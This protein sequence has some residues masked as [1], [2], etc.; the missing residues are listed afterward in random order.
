MAD[1]P[2]E[3]R[4]LLSAVARIAGER[5]T[6]V[7]LV[8]GAVRD[9]LLGRRILDVD[10]AVEGDA[11]ALARAAADDVGARLRAHEA[12]GTAVVMLATGRRVDLAGTRSEVYPEVAALPRVRPASLADD[13][14]RRDFT[15]NSMAVP[16]DDPDGPPIDPSGGAGDLAARRLRVHHARSFL[17]DP[18]RIV[19]GVRFEARLGFRLG[20]ETERLARQACAA[21]AVERLSAERLR[22]E[23]ELLFEDEG[24]LEWT[25]RRLGELGVLAAA[26]LDGG[27]GAATRLG[28]VSRALDGWT[29]RHGAEYEVRR[30]RTLLAAALRTLPPGARDAAARRL[31]IAA[32]GAEG[33]E[34]LVRAVGRPSLRPRELADTLETLD[35][36]ELVLLEALGGSEIGERV[37]VHLAAQRRLELSIDGS[38][39]LAHGFAAGPHIGAA[40]RATRAARH[41]GLITAGEELAFALAA[42]RGENR[43]R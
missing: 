6:S 16:L 31:G 26:G 25:W 19:R 29:G 34:D 10:L 23:L 22:T 40:L 38:T 41:D 11:I 21:H 3:V 27:E 20:T 13:L 39:L 4:T 36:E 5:E 15:V 33:F 2:P 17:D 9:R 32:G 7:Y 30:S 8:G 43:E 42:L 24:D 1:L 14:R 37:A 12:F 28:S 35:L 18:T